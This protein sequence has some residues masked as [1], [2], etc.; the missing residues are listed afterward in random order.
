MRAR[1]RTLGGNALLNPFSGSRLISRFKI[2]GERRQLNYPWNKAARARASDRYSFPGYQLGGGKGGK[3]CVHARAQKRT[4]ANSTAY[5]PAA[6]A[7]VVVRMFPRRKRRRR[8][9][10]RE[11]YRGHLSRK[12]LIRERRG[13]ERKARRRRVM[14]QG[15]EE[16]VARGVAVPLMSLTF[17]SCLSVSFSHSFSLFLSLS[18]DASAPVSLPPPRLHICLFYW[19]IIYEVILWTSC[20]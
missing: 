20:A 4:E 5:L 6:A 2:Y 9:S 16:D 14:F 1:D 10:E 19:F 8:E 15:I 11:S 17:I 7:A 13:G 12:R 18:L 3:K